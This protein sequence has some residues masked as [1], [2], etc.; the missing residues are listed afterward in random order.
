VAARALGHESAAAVEPDLDFLDAGFNSL[1]AV[2]FRNALNRIT[3]LSLPAA[4]VYDYP[5]P[6]AVVEFLESELV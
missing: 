4:L 5:T 2:E 3:G 1:S 6:N